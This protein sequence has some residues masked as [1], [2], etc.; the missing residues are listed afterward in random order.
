MNSQRERR[1]EPRPLPNALPRIQITRVNAR[2]PM[3][4]AEQRVALLIWVCSIC[5]AVLAATKIC[6]ILYEVCLAI[7]QAL[8]RQ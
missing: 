5:I 1:L 2:V 7:G 4:R 3:N 6:E 8:A